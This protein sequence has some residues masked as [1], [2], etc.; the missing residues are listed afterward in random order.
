MRITIEVVIETD[1]AEAE[2]AALKRGHGEPAAYIFGHADCEHDALLPHEVEPDT[3]NEHPE[4]YTALYTSAPSIPEGYVLVPTD[5][6]DEWCYRF[7]ENT[8][9][10]W[11]LDSLRREIRN[12]LAAAPKHTSTTNHKEQ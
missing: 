5:P 3:F 7:E 12:V 8:F 6:S 11:P 9:K 2:L 10:K 4:F 1:E